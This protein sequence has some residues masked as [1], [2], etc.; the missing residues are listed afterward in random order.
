MKRTAVVRLRF[1]SEKQLEITTRALLPETRKPPTKRFRVN[2]EKEG[3]VLI[4]KIEA[5]DTVALR[6][7]L[8]VYLRW[9]ESTK[10]VLE[11]LQTFR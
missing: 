9:I 4:L 2:L 8:N 11:L 7:A 3:I 10:N 1:P 5:N 6:A